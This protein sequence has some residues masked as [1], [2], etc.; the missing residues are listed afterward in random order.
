MSTHAQSGTLAALVLA[1]LGC[2]RQPEPASVTTT[3]SAAF[4]SQGANDDITTARC[5]REQ[6]CSR[7]G[8]GQKYPSFDACR[9]TLAPDTRATAR[10]QDCR[11]GVSDQSLSNCLSDIRNEPCE[12]DLGTI[13]TYRACTRAN[14]CR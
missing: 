10:P 12:T 14:L 1:V 5:N 13:A 4:V 7:V 8:A 9:D 2:A 11:D 3:T 6:A